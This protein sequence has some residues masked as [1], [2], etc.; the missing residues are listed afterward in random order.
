[1]QATLASHW[2]Y[3]PPGQQ[4][5]AAGLK[6]AKHAGWLAKAVEAN[7]SLGQVTLFIVE[8]HKQQ[9]RA[10][11]QQAS[12]NNSRQGG[13]LHCKLFYRIIQVNTGLL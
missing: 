8:N 9:P 4:T 7:R 6:A 12:S 3:T 13:I 5:E 10:V 2:Q 1:M 11:Q